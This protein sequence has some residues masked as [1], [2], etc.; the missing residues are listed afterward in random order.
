MTPV[1]AIMALVILLLFEL[2]PAYCGNRVAL[3]FGNGLYKNARVLANPA[4]DA[5]DMAAILQKLGFTVILGTDLGKSA[6]KSKIDEFA[7][8]LPGADAGLFYYSGHALQ[9]GSVNYLVPVDAAIESTD[10]LG[11]ETLSLQ[12]IQQTMEQNAKTSI[13]FLDACRNN[14]LSRDA[15]PSKGMRPV[16]LE[17][18]LA[19]MKAGA[20]TLISFSTAPGEWAFDGD[21]RN[22]PYTGALVSN[23]GSP[24]EDIVSILMDVRKA[25]RAATDNRQTP[26][27][28]SALMDR[29]YLNTAR[30]VSE[31]P[32]RPVPPRPT[33][34]SVANPASIEQIR[35]VEPDVPAGPVR[36]CDGH[37]CGRPQE[38]EI[39]FLLPF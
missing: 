25:V 4:N 39:P 15:S 32:R 12:A 6:M 16:A 7:R 30:Q 5:R 27:E 36:P 23:I 2:A 18:G 28:H 11:P 26:W 37:N 9:A 35:N 24:G 21:G 3:V 34:G 19:Q 29:V 33:P 13:L 14:P 20:G 8:L 22:S 38:P 31:A 1:R 17:R 10:S